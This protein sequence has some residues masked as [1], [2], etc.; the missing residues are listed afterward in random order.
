[1]FEDVSESSV[2][3]VDDNENA[4][5]TGVYVPGTSGGTLIGKPI[6]IVYAGSGGQRV[7][8]GE[9]QILVDELSL[10]GIAGETLAVIARDLN[11]NGVALNWSLT[12]IE[13]Q[14]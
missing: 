6:N 9:G 2:L 10:D 1:M 14:I 4:Q 3:E 8:G 5:A 12:W 7:E 13:R 11:G